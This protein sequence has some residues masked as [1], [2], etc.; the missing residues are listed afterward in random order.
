MAEVDL[1]PPPAHI[2]NTLECAHAYTFNLPHVHTGNMLVCAHACT[3][4]P[5]CTLYA[6]SLCV[7]IPKHATLHMLI[8]AIHLS[9]HMPIHAILH[10]QY[11]CMCMSPYN[12]LHK[13][14]MV[15]NLRGSKK[16]LC[17]CVCGG[18]FDVFS[19]VS[20]WEAQCN[21]SWEC[22]QS[23]SK[24]ADIFLIG[25]I[26]QTSGHNLSTQIN[27]PCLLPGW[28]N[29]PLSTQPRCFVGCMC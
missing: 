14:K 24:F 4:N 5:P 16:F 6:I 27:H 7:H 17:V 1:S 22:P 25:D 2:D 26:S 9:V 19:L 12:Q 15:W 13:F 11:V 20:L 8:Q 21:I 18:L 10:M 3:C 28:N 23:C 29:I